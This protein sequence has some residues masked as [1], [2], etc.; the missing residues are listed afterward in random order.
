[1]LKVL[2]GPEVVIISAE[3]RLGVGRACVLEL[4][5]AVIVHAVV[6]LSNKDTGVVLILLAEVELIVLVA[7][8][9]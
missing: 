7:A 6:P 4:R 2:S 9:C 8:D 1:M 3:V 5:V